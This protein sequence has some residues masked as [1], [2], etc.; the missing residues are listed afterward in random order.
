VI[1]VREGLARAQAKLEEAVAGQEQQEKLGE[2][3][4]DTRASPWT[5]GQNG[6]AGNG[7]D[8]VTSTATQRRRAEASTASRKGPISSRS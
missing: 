8:G 3:G 6:S 5:G 1:G 7:G 2:P 4:S